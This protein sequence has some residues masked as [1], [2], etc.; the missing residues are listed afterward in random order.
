MMI[1]SN[2]LVGTLLTLFG[3]V[4]LIVS[5]RDLVR[6]AKSE[7]W[8]SVVGHVLKSEVLPPAG[9]YARDYGAM[10]EFRYTV[11]EREYTGDRIQFLWIDGSR[12][13]AESTIARYPAG[14]KVEVRVSPQDPALAVLEPGMRRYAYASVLIP[15]V[16][17]AIGIVFILRAIL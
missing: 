15:A 17:L 7:A 11:G 4:T 2:L 8:P 1:Y 3:G 9:H 13:K 10:V 16:S 6:A 5:V 12:A 14:S